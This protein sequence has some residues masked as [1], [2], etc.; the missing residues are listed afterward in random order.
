MLAIV[1]VSFSSCEKSI[2]DLWVSAVKGKI[3]ASF[4]YSI[5]NN[6]A[7]AIVQFSNTS[8]N[9]DSYQ[10]SFG[11][12]LSSSEESPSHKFEK[13]GTF[14]VKLIATRSEDSD[15]FTKSITIE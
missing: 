4:T 1:A 3:V 9:S 11:D 7:P 13:S 6:K 5:E 14:S 8:S 15:T 12:G 10:W 2:S